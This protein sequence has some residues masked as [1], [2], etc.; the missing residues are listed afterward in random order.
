MK[1]YL[2]DVMIHTDSETITLNDIKTGDTIRGNF[3]GDIVASS[4]EIITKVQS[5]TLLKKNSNA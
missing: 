3:M 2:D 5:V 1:M 4:P